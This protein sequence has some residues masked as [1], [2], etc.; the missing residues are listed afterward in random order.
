MVCGA[1]S[2][3]MISGVRAEMGRVTGGCSIIVWFGSCVVICGLNGIY[4]DGIMWLLFSL[5]LWWEWWIGL[6]KCRFWRH[7]HPEPHIFKRYWWYGSNSIMVA[8]WSH[9]LSLVF[10]TTTFIPTVSLCKTCALELQS[11]INRLYFVE[12]LFSQCSAGIIHSLCS[13]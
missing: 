3:A 5:D 10:W 8:V 13:F 9:L 11:L 6:R 12:R 2:A 7:M 4:G 1:W